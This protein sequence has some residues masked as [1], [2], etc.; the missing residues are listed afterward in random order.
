MKVRNQMNIGNK[1]W[2]IAEGWIPPLGD[3]TAVFLNV[4]PREA[5]VQL[6]V[7]YSNRDPVG[8]YRLTIPAGRLR[9]VRF[10]GLK[11]PPPVERALYYTHPIESPQPI[12]VPPRL[13]SFPPDHMAHAI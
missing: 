10:N 9:R 5:H 8:P 11:S 13:P 12:V 1:H 3:E 7:Y 6:F 4:S 2:T